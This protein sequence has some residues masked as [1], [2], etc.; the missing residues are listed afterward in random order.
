VNVRVSLPAL[1]QV[2]EHPPQLLHEPMQFTG[3]DAELQVCVC[4]P[5]FSAPYVGVQG[6]PPAEAADD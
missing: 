3:H 5:P 4:V 6:T 2:Q 1:P